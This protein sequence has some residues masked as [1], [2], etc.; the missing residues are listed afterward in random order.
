MAKFL[1]AGVTIVLTL[2]LPFTAQTQTPPPSQ[3]EA[4]LIEK[5]KGI[6]D[7][8]IKIDTHN[9]INPALFR[10]ECNYTM[11]LT[12]Q[13]NLPKMIDGD[14][15]VSFMIVYV[16]QGPLT[17]QGYENAHRQ[18]I[19]KF[20]AIHRLTEKLAPQQIGLALAPAD[21]L[22]LH[23]RGLRIAAIGVE[24]GYSIGTDIRRVKEFYD[25]GARYMSLAHNGK[26]QLADSNTGETQRYEE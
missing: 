26:S 12:T 18:A 22:K 19:A 8:V 25:R 23:D 15:D 4:G 16:D 7:R 13:V 2:T 20:D 3:A 9:D 24:N 17:P 10:P 14:M 6:H 1:I 21:V 11:R 5:A